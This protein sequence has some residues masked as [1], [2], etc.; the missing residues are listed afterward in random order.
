MTEAAA[1][2]LQSQNAIDM[3]AKAASS[4]NSSQPHRATVKAVRNSEQGVDGDRAA[5]NPS[6]QLERSE[7]WSDG[8]AVGATEKISDKPRRD[9]DTEADSTASFEATIDKLGVE[10]SASDSA[11]ATAQTPPAGWNIE[12]VARQMSNDPPESD[13][14]ENG[15]ATLK[16]SS[17]S[18]PSAVMLKQ[19][20]VQALL[21]TRQRLQDIEND[22]TQMPAQATEE[23]VTSR[24]TVDQH[25][26]HWIFDTRAPAANLRLPQDLAPQGEKAAPLAASAAM[27]STSTSRSDGDGAAKT[28]AGDTP[29]AT[30]APASARSAN[31]SEAQLHQGSDGARDGRPD[32]RAQSTFARQMSSSAPQAAT[33]TETR[34]SDVQE[35]AAGMSGATQQVRSGVV[36]ALTSE[37]NPEPL[38]RPP[39][40]V[41]RPPVAGQVLRTIDLTLSPPDLGTVRLKLSLKSN[42]LDI[43][44]ETSKAATAK[45]LED[46]RK[47]L[48]QSLRDAGYDVKSLKIAETSAAGNSS[49]NS[50]LNNGSAPQDGNQARANF[51]GRQDEN[52]QRRDGGGSDHPQQRSR[53]DNPKAAAPGAET[54]SSRQTDAVYI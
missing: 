2:P 36:S 31:A 13:R 47:G 20:S 24:L 44:A 46:D 5:A 8:K 26:S 25:R 52:M 29:L 33:K 50:S 45:M 18:A 23:T 6:S 28:S 11:T 3:L 30:S 37:A 15:V 48:E 17:N 41:D 14:A 1:R 35:P 34:S 39:Q 43:D 38:S 16:Y 40:L 4:K 22:K 53:N 51:A 27:T 19:E 54:T 21:D 49:L 32:A 7:N 9:S 10:K 42:A 12:L